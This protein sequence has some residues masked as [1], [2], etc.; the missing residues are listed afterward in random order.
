[1][2]ASRD[3]QVESNIASQ[4]AFNPILRRYQK[5]SQS[6]FHQRSHAAIGQIKPKRIRHWIEAICPRHEH[7]QR[8]DHDDSEQP[9]PLPACPAGY[10]I[11]A[12][13]FADILPIG[14]LPLLGRALR[15][16]ARVSAAGLL[17]MLSKLDAS[18]DCLCW[19]ASHTPSEPL[20]LLSQGGL[21][22]SDRK[23][24]S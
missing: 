2:S 15:G 23:L 19:R 7:S 22:Q 11:F 12:S 6:Q 20:L 18:P 21:G 13:W 1:V 9:K 10:A 24:R 17:C 5:A 16:H 8:I 4:M 3:V 14:V